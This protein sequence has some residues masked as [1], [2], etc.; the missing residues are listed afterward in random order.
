M[1]D[2]LKLLIEV[3]RSSG[4]RGWF[5]LGWISMLITV[6]A[7]AEQQRPTALLARA[8]GQAGF[9]D[10]A[11]WLIAD[12]PVIV[13]AGSRD[14]QTLFVV[15]SAIVFMLM[16]GSALNRGCG[17]PGRTAEEALASLETPAAPALWIILCAAV[18]AGSVPRLPELLVDVPWAWIGGAA[19][20]TV[21]GYALAA[22]VPML[23]P[24]RPMA[25]LCASVLLA[26]GCSAAA[27]V[28]LLV[29]IPH[30]IARALVARHGETPPDRSGEIP[31]QTMPTGAVDRPRAFRP[32]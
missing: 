6:V 24:L 32:G 20:A 11:R 31:S 8:A 13:T 15:V 17:R 26:I 2:V 19:A 4:A 9:D 12:G 3:I 10:L 21:A 7:V 27:A 18:S 28:F 23:R 5:I 14:L 25:D 16:I 30:G 29:T 22:R 1:S